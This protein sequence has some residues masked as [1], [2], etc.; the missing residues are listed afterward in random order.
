MRGGCPRLGA[1]TIAVARPP[2]GSC[3]AA[4]LDL[5]ICCISGNHSP[6]CIAAALPPTV[7]ATSMGSGGSGADATLATSPASCVTWS[8]TSESCPRRA[9]CWACESLNRPCKSVNWSANACW[10]TSASVKCTM[11][12]CMACTLV[13]KSL[14]CCCCCWT[15]CSSNCSSLLRCCCCCTARSRT[16]ISC[17]RFMTAFLESTLLCETVPCSCIMFCS[18]AF[19]V[20]PCCAISLERCSKFWLTWL[21]TH[22]RFCRSCS[23]SQACFWNV[24]LAFSMASSCRC[25]AWRRSFSAW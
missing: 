25:C 4:C 12:S 24:A 17:P 6:C 7:V 20:T 2:C 19:M 11:A 23:T 5:T 16:A 18:S 8:R 13:C 14:I 3:S 22:M 21:I 1:A 9:C 15:V 10:R